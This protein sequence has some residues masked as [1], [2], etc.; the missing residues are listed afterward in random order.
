[1]NNKVCYIYIIMSETVNNIVNQVKSL[2]KKDYNELLSWLSNYELKHMD[3]WDKEIESD[4][5]END[6][7]NKMISD[8]E[9]DIKK[10]RTKSLDEVLNNS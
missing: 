1:V 7:L 8:A 4:L 2:S 9:E 3:N 5:I 6:N 10:G